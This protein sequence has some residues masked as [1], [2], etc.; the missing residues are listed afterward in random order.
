MQKRHSTVKR[1]FRKKNLWILHFLIRSEKDQLKK[2]TQSSENRH[3]FSTKLTKH[4]Q[5]KIKKKRTSPGKCTEQIFIFHKVINNILKLIL[6]KINLFDAFR[7]WCFFSN[8]HSIEMFTETHFWP[9]CTSLSSRTLRSPR[10]RRTTQRSRQSP[11]IGIRVAFRWLAASQSQ[12]VVERANSSSSGSVVYS[13][14]LL[15]VEDTRTKKSK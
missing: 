2:I 1:D 8:F 5:L 10:A 6:R 11:P 12:C 4:L 15:D 13:Q 14:K 3:A 9:D 7:V